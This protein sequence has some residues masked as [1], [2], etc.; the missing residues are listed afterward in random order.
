MTKL[1]GFLKTENYIITN[2]KHNDNVSDDGYKNNSRKII[3]QRS[4]YFR[5]RTMWGANT[6]SRS[7]YGPVYFL[8]KKTV[9]GVTSTSL[10]VANYF[11]G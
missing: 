10:L 5:F 2:S 1:S 9:T 4:S 11:Y 8:Q 3:K 6:I 7:N